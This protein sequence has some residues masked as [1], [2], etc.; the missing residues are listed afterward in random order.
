[1]FRTWEFNVKPLLKPEENTIE[2]AF[3]P[4]V[5]YV[6]APGAKSRMSRLGRVGDHKL[7]GG[8]WI[9]KEPCNFGWDWGPMLATSGIWREPGDHRLQ[10][11]RAWTRCTSASS[12]PT[13]R[14]TLAVCAGGRV[15]PEKA[16][17][18]RGH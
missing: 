3:D 13:V 4:P 7:D 16:R 14:V 9:R 18:G 15:A 2:I 1:M 6:R 5:P 11:A 17:R 12:T 10:T 8:G